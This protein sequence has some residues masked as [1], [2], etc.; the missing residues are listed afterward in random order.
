MAEPDD[1]KRELAAL[2][3][4]AR[5]RSL[6]TLSSAPGRLVTLDGREVLNLSSN[7]YLGLADH[8]ALK[9][10]SIAATE[11]AG[12]GAAAS[13]LILGNQREHEDFERE[14]A[15]FHHKPAAL[16]FNSGYNANVGVLQ[17]I[18]RAGD[19]IF[20][21]ALNHAS[22]IDGCR[23]SR[24]RV[25][26]YPHADV[27]ALAELI[28]REHASA[29]E[30]AARAR[31]IVVTDAVFS[32]DGDRAPLRELSAL[33]ERTGAVLVVDEAHSVALSGPG[34]RGLAAELGAKV[35]V[36]VGTL[37]KA[38]GSFGGY[39]AGSETLR[40]LLLNRARSFVFTTALPPGVVAA[41]RAALALVAGE[42]GEA[43][44][45]RLADNIERFRRGLAALG[46]L[47][48][49]VGATPI[50]PVLVG[51][52]ARTM[53]CTRLLLERGLYVQG[54]RPP[55]VPAGTSRLRF[56]LM[57]THTADDLDRALSELERLA[58]AGLLG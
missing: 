39:V 53:E 42:E 33:C 17:T 25:I 47:V 30:G 16:L 41:T 31:R 49:N 21:D 46:L 23:L 29:G 9:R 24:A 4:D 15:R 19:L 13:R 50:F 7:N 3:A 36:H 32:M 11:R 20:S 5:R 14:L 26:V 57:A 40:A 48:E 43:L 44:R 12:T 27:A 22:I 45:A 1:W 18:A 37:S 35:D 2:E 8:P 34:G 56:A 52:E 55:T 6:R 54:I 51:D 58:S 38:L 28:A 10:A